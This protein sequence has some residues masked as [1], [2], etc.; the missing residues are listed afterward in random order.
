[1]P[2]IGLF[3]HP[4]ALRCSTQRLAA[5]MAARRPA[6]KLREDFITDCA[7]ITRHAG[8]VVTAAEYSGVVDRSDP[9]DSAM[10][11]TSTVMLSIETRPTTGAVSPA[12]STD[13]LLPSA[14][15]IRQHIRRQA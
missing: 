7:G 12:I 15:D 8:K 2:R 14:R 6:A 3:D 13:A 4:P 9:R 5:D 1:M 10:S 11:V